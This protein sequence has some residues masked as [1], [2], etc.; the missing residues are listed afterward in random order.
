MVSCQAVTGSG[1]DTLVLADDGGLSLIVPSTQTGENGDATLWIDGLSSPQQATL[2]GGY[3]TVA[4]N[5]VAQSGLEKGR[6]MALQISDGKKR[7]Y[8]LAGTTAAIL[9]AQA[10]YAE[11]TGAPAP[12]APPAITGENVGMAYFD[13]GRFRQR[14]DGSW[15]EEDVGGA[16][17]E[18]QESARTADSVTLTD[19]DTRIRIDTT[20]M[21]ILQARGNG[22]FAEIHAITGLDTYVSPRAG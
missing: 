19:G 21:Q 5:A 11:K 7:S 1:A 12:E 17:R 15:I 13:G 9:K 14:V 18:F 22:A 6:E 2:S 8:A 10:C 20:S 4:V 16:T 3:A